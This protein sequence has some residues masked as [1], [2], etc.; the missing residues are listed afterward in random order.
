[1]VGASHKLRLWRNWDPHII[2]K[3][4][5]D[6]WMRAEEIAPDGYDLIFDANG[7]STLSDSYDHLRRPGKLVIYGFASI[8]QIKRSS[9][10]VEA[11]YSL[12]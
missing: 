4:A 1:M 6:L 3:G 9:E 10:L 5:D 7:V 12:L 8:L 11:R 2:D